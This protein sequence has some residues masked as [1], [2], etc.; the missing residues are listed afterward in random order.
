MKTSWTFLVFALYF[1]GSDNALGCAMFAASED[2]KVLIGANEDWLDPDINLYFVPATKDKNGYVIYGA[3]PLWPETGMNDQGLVIDFLRTPYLETTNP[4]NKE[5]LVGNP[6]AL[7]LETCN[8][9][10]DV[11]EILESHT[12]GGFEQGQMMIADG[13]GDAAIVEGDIIH[14]KNSAAMIAT[15]FLHSQVDVNDCPSCIRYRIVSGM[16]NEQGVSVESFRQTLKAIH[17]E[18]AWGGTQYSNI[19]VPQD[20]LIHIYLFHNYEDRVTLNLHE[21]LEK[22][23]RSVRLAALF[24]R[25]FA[26]ETYVESMPDGDWALIIDVLEREGPEAALDR[27]DS[28][29]EGVRKIQPIVDEYF[30][31][32]PVDI[33]G[34]AQEWSFAMVA[35]EHWKIRRIVGGPRAVA[36]AVSKLA[37]RTELGKA[38]TLGVAALKRYAGNPLLL[39]SLGNVYIDAGNTAS[40]LSTYRALDEAYPS[41]NHWKSEMYERIQAMDSSD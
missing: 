28:L 10:A 26:Y 5:I 35:G 11:L 8:S 6:A 13:T 18:G 1:L 40:A 9:V 22:G 24:P 32:A 7:F 30:D 25:N 38:E 27:A 17:F 34:Q 29:A 37:E 39:Y 33:V 3:N 41:N 23:A 20:G 2:G 36:T 31:Q 12:L 15:N 4:Q 14:R 16:L 19:Y 21:E